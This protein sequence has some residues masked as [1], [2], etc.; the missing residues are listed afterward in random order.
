MQSIYSSN[1]CM[2]CFDCVKNFCQFRKELISSQN[3]LYQVFSTEEEEK[4]DSV[5]NRNVNATTNQPQ[6][7]EENF[8]DISQAVKIKLEAPENDNFANQVMSFVSDDMP[9]DGDPSLTYQFKDESQNPDL[10]IYSEFHRNSIRSIRYTIL[11]Y[12]YY[13]QVFGV[14]MQRNS[15]R[16]CPP[17]VIQKRSKQKNLEIH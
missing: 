2:K 7:Q 16:Q 10:T 5:V 12:F 13:L 15:I 9:D 3:I 1:I 8:I 6:Q 11:N 4:D 17:Q 14:N